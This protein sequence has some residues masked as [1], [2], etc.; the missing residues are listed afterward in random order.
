M[1]AVILSLLLA[2]RGG[3]EQQHRPN[4]VIINW[5]TTR[6]DLLSAYG[7]PQATSPNL[8]SLAREGV[9]FEQ[10]HSAAPWTL[11]SVA[12]LFTGLG[13]TAHGVREFEDVLPA[14]AETLAEAL[15]AQ[16]YSTVALASN[17]IFEAQ[18]GLEQGFDRYVGEGDLEGERLLREL[19][20][21]LGERPA[22]QPFFLY[23]HLFEPHCPYHP[24]DVYE[25]VYRPR[26]AALR[27]GR[28]YS[29]EYWAKMFGCF[30][31]PGPGRPGDPIYEIDE[32]L[33]AY[34]AEL[35]H[36]DH[37]TG[38]VLT[39]L[40]SRELLDDSLVVVLGDHGEEFLDHGD[41]GHGRQL[42]QE[43]LRVPLL[44]RPPGGPQARAAFAGRRV[45]APTSTLDVSATVRAAVGLP[46]VGPGQDLSPAWGEAGPPASWE[47]RPI[48][49]GTDHEAHRR[50][51]RRGRFK[52][53]AE[54]GPPTEDPARALRPP[55]LFDL[56]ADPGE[57]TDLAHQHLATA[58]SLSALLAEQ[59]KADLQ[60]SEKIGRQRRAL[61]RET[62]EALRRL[63]YLE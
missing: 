35:N 63:G 50:M 9:L 8:E 55:L 3:A 32:Y 22:D 47:D 15:R 56:Q 4:V 57:R 62:E 21:W 54:V 26:P 46:P 37:L 43:S 23:M 7:H 44:I 6:A 59:E 29:P 28:A 40:R 52:L 30:Q 60:A 18:R 49:A 41:H 27:T 39:A 31:L 10:N 20:A 13:P 2:C 53:I 42:F 34:E 19:Q 17:S 24:P 61:D 45:A 12:S 48:F 38:L 58:R 33:G 16:G 11:P 14:R 1:S 36:A 5:E 51:I 25:G